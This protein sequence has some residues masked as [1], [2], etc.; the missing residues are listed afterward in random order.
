MSHEEKTQRP[1]GPADQVPV[2]ER[3]DDG[4]SRPGGGHDEVAMAIM[5][6]ALDH[7]ILEH[8]ALV[9]VR[10]Y[11][12]PAEARARDVLRLA[13]PL[14]PERVLKSLRITAGLV[15]L[16]GVVVPIGVKRR[17]HALD[18][19]RGLGL[20][21]THV[22]LKPGMHGGMGEVRG[23]HKGRGQPVRS[24]HD[25]RLGV[26][27]RALSVEANSHIG[28][29][30]AQGTNRLWISDPHV[31]RRDHS[32]RSIATDQAAEFIE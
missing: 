11:D 19:R 10:D 6:V 13:L 4:L 26:Q 29:E 5:A 3:R 24:V 27:L 22:P 2:V 18:D 23:A 1:A 21:E 25:P 20:G 32:D 7:Q 12:K 8:P 16:E 30:L 15:L 9:R 31:G 14:A 17:S 28:T